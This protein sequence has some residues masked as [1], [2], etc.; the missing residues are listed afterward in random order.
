MSRHRAGRSDDR[1]FVSVEMVMAFAF[2]LLL[3]TTLTN[4][5][6]VQY[7]RGIMR[8]AVDESARAGARVIENDTIDLNAVAKCKQR[9]DDVLKGLGK[10][11][12][13]TSSNCEVVDGRVQSTVSADFD[14][15]LPGIPTFSDTATAVSVKEQAPQ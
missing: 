8:A 15:W 5:I 11:G 3:L 14:G 6:L 13:V 1:G 2:S 9:Q 7:G 10:L 12:S 4:L